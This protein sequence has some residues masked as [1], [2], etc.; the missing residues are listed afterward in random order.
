MREPKSKNAHI[1]H[2]SA[3]KP[4]LGARAFTV[5]GHTNGAYCNNP[6]KKSGHVKNVCL[7][8]CHFRSG[9]DWAFSAKTAALIQFFRILQC[10]R[11]DRLKHP[12]Q[13]GTLHTSARKRANRYLQERAKAIN[14]DV[15][16]NSALTKR[17]QVK[18]FW[19]QMRLCNLILTFWNLN[20]TQQ[21]WLYLP[22]HFLVV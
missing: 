6:V 14:P 20:K 18:N 9:P 12:L 13:H 3:A 7:A 16:P 4:H 11:G 22:I 2:W 17:Y 5:Q 15:R 21:N 8:E 10:Q 19:L 1:R